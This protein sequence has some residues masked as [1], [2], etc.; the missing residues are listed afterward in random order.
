MPTPT[1]K[2]SD[3]LRA[4]LD[5]ELDALPPGHALPTDR[6]LARTW[7]LSS[8]TVRRVLGGFAAQGRV[9]RIPGK[10]TF[11]PGSAPGG[12]GEP[13]RVGAAAT[14]ADAIRRGIQSGTFRRGA[15]LPS[16][17]SL[18]LQFRVS[19]PTVTR[20]YR[21]LQRQGH[22]T[23][24]GRSFW[25]G[26]FEQLVRGG[27]RSLVYLLRADDRGFEGVFRQDML[28]PAY[29]RLER[30]LSDHGTV[31]VCAGGDEAR[32]V[33][34][35]YARDLSDLRG[36]VFY[37]ITDDTYASF[38][39]PLLGRFRASVRDHVP[40]LIDNV[41]DFRADTAGA[42]VLTRGNISTAA[43]RAAAQSIVA[44]GMTSA[45][46]FVDATSRYD[47][48]RGRLWNFWSLMKLRTELL[49]LNPA[50]AC[51]VHARVSGAGDPEQALSRL[52]G[53]LPKPHRRSI[54]G[55]YHDTGAGGAIPDTVPVTDLTASIAAAP[56]ADIWVFASHAMAAEGLRIA[57]ERRLHVPRDLSILSLENDPR[58]Y[59]LSISCCEPDWDTIGYLMAHAILGDIAVER[60][61]RGFLRTRA[62]VV[63]KMTTR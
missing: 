56:P 35:R 41:T 40:V 34:R 15:C 31:L 55:K 51:T 53:Q 2:P 20:A 9:S 16:A 7:G 50:F 21:E 28:A 61:T 39:K 54:L 13:R 44:A 26:P 38:V 24:I 32:S 52:A 59:H 58:Y 49:Q 60:T 1:P 57:R 45:R 62:R 25:V 33:V 37:G 29:C 22:V 46:L 10:G 47:P 4:W 42:T 27:G 8:R 19:P 17:K 43:A 14:V 48:L 63:G 11:V 23:R 6:E 18:C 5:T 36:L 12:D 30:E 3:K